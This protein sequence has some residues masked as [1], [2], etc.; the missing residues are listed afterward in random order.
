MKRFSYFV[1]AF[2]ILVS[3][4]NS[5]DKKPQSII[6]SKD[7]MSFSLPKYW[8]VKKDRPIDGVANSRFISVSN[9]E[10]FAKDAYLIITRIDS[11]S[12][13]NTLQNLIQQSRAS[14]SKRKV[15]FGMLNEPKVEKIGN[16]E[17]LKANFETR[18]I[19]NRN[20]GS[21]AVLHYK[22][23]T[24]CFVSSINI[25]DKKA[26]FSVADSVIKSLSVK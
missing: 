1:W 15:E 16:H 10:P 22:G 17:V 19:T 12:L 26:N 25:K 24:F 3:A 13:V 18:V 2:I 14:Y 21:F 11:V 5:S 9:E 8:K 6:Y 23:K 7:G 20:R 4:C